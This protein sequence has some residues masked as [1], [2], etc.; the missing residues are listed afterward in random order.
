MNTMLPS[1]SFLVFVH[2]ESWELTTL[3]RKL[4]PWLSSHPEDELVIVD[5]F[6]TDDATKDVLRTSGDKVVQHALN[7]DFSTHKNFG[8]SHCSK[9]FILQIDADEYPTESLLENLKELIRLNPNVE[10]FRLPRVNLVRGLTPEHAQKWG[11]QVYW[12]DAY[13]D[14]PCVNMQD[15]QGRLY[16]NDPTRI[17][18]VRPVHEVIVGHNGV[19]TIPFDPEFAL[20]H[21]KTI[22]RQKQQNMLYDK[23][24]RR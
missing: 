23:M 13:K 20:I 18:W 22:E 4:H 3:L 14:V 9:N 11:W 1:I 17:K 21:D 15:H 8:N 5:D 24:M 12:L 6:S 19:A 7:G 2:N 16:R 10:L